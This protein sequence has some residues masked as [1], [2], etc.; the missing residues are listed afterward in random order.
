MNHPQAVI[1]MKIKFEK[2]TRRQWLRLHRDKYH[3]TASQAGAVLGVNPYDSPETLWYLRTGRSEPFEGNVATMIGHALEKTI[4]ELYKMETGTKLINPGGQYGIVRHPD[5]PWLFCTLDRLIQ[6]HNESLRPVPFYVP[7]ELKWSLSKDSWG[8]DTIPLSYEVQ[9]QIQMACIGAKRGVLVALV[10]H[11]DIRIY[12]RDYDPDLMEAIIP[13]LLEF[14]QNV[15]DD[16]MPEFNYS[17]SATR[18]FIDKLHPDDNGESIALS[19]DFDGLFGKR[20]DLNADMKL[21]KTEMSE[22]DAKVKATLAENTFGVTTTGLGRKVSY[23]TISNKNGSSYRRLY[24]PKG[25]NKG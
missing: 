23:K 14:R 19:P 8:E 12:E 15:M 16:E 9:L 3:V 17:H 10:G 21:I 7:V 6:T 18:E 5:H 22:I 2:L 4:A 24:Y 25:S 13:K 11:S 1:M 20:N